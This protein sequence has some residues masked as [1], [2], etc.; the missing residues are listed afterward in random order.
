MKV[1]LQP[2]EHLEIECVGTGFT[3]RVWNTSNEKV[4]PMVSATVTGPFQGNPASF[5]IHSREVL[6]A[7]RTD[8]P[9]TVSDL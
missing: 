4:R 2:G 8:R 9:P 1:S 3:Y 7:Y 6:Q 5:L